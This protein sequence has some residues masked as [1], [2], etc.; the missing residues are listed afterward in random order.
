MDGIS[1]DTVYPARVLPSID[2][3]MELRHPECP[4]RVSAA[5]FTA[6]SVKLPRCVTCDR[7]AMLCMN[8]F[9]LEAGRAA[10]AADI[11]EV[12]GIC[13]EAQRFASEAADECAKAA[14]SGNHG[15][16]DPD[17]AARG[18][19]LYSQFFGELGDTAAKAVSSKTQKE[20][21]RAVA[22]WKA[23]LRDRSD[24]LALGLNIIEKASTS[25]AP[26]NF[27]AADYQIAKF[28]GGYFVLRP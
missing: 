1:A 15:K 23:H 3:E 25:S 8:I 4:V 27:A 16:L 10:W 26:K 21:D 19:D 9:S 12:P 17:V 22:H 13:A 6:L 14:S 24:T 11:R 2:A 5:A 18:I 20:I 7:I 28:V